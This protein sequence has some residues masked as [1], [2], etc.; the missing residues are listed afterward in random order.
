VFC[1]L[2]E[3]THSSGRHIDGQSSSGGFDPEGL[4][5]STGFQTWQTAAVMESSSRVSSSSSSSIGPCFET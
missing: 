1:S 5:V 2:A 3:G 4:Q